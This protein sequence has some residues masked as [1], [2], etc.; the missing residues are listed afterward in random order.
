MEYKMMVPPIEVGDFR[1]LSKK[2][3]DEHFKWYI[4]QIP[5]RL[6][7]LQTY[8]NNEK[9]VNVKLDFSKNSLVRLWQWFENYM[10]TEKKSNE[11]LAIELRKYPEWIHERINDQE[12][13][14]TLETMI[15]GMD[16]ALYFAETIIKNNPS[17]EWGY[18]TKPKNRM[19]VNKPVLIGF[20]GGQDL[21]PREIILNCMRKSER[22]KNPERL[23]NT[24]DIW[25]D[26]I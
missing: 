23:M 2:Q 25:I 7:Q 4:A 17:I 16:L 26:E 19:S 22:D 12:Y 14:F 8:I 3:T 6:E 20:K 5:Y 15:I 1:E 11:E 13:K 10:K 18:F 21:D 9:K 24:Y